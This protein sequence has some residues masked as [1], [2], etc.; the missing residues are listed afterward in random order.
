LI[1]P[2]IR[3]LE[4]LVASVDAWQIVHVYGGAEVVRAM[5]FDAIDIDLST[6]WEDEFE[7]EPT[8]K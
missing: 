8:P 6:L 7:R 1:D 3:T 5:P 4:V 2:A